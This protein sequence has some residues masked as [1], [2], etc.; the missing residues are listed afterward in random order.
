LVRTDPRERLVRLLN[1]VEQVIRLDEKVVLQLSDYRLPDGTSFAF[2]GAE[3]RDLPGVRLGARDDEGPVWLEVARLARQ[4]PP[5]P[6]AEIA[7]W[8]VPS[9]DPA[10]PPRSRSRRLI[11][12]DAA[13]RDLAVANGEVRPE[14]VAETSRKA[15]GPT[16][17]PPSFELTLRLDQRP[18]VA[19]KIAEWIA[20]PWSKWA[21]D[22]Q[23]RRGTI[24]IYQQLYKL[25][26]MI[27]VG[28]YESPI[29]LIWG[30]GLV[31]WQKDGRVVDRPLLEIRADLE[32][33]DTSGGLIR[34]R[35]TGGE[36]TFD[37]KP[38]EELGCE[39][40][41]LGELPDLIRRE[42]KKS[43]EA[44]GLSPFAPDSFEPILAA[45]ASRLGDGG[46]Y[47]QSAN[48][49]NVEIDPKQLTVTDQWVLFARPRSQH[50]L[51]QDIGRLRSVLED[52]DRPI[53]GL[54]ERL[55]TEPSK[56]APVG[57]WTPPDRI[58]AT[59]GIASPTQDEAPF[60]VFFPKPYNDDQ[61]ELVRR[62]KQTD[63]FVVQGPPGT[64]K[65]HTIANLICHAMATGERVLVVS[66]G[67]AA[68]AVLKD[69][70]PKEVQPLA[71]AV[72]SNE[73]QGLR[74]LERAIREIE[75]V[76]EGT[77]PEKR[78]SAIRRL[79]AEIDGLRKRIAAI[80]QELDAIAAPHFS[81]IGPRGE[82]AV[83]LA[84]RVVAERDTF[85]WFT[86]R[87]AN[88]AAETALSEQDITT[89]ADARRRAGDFLD[90][91]HVDLPLPANLPSVE[92]VR[93]WHDDLV[94]ASQL[95]ENDAHQPEDTSDQ[96]V[97]R[98]RIPSDEVD[99]ASN[100]AEVLHNFAA[101]HPASLG[102]PWIEPLRRAAVKGDSPPSLTMLRE[103]LNEWASLDVDRPALARRSVEL[104]PGLLESA[105][106]REAVN[107][108]AA[109]ERPWSL[110]STGK[111]TA[112][113]LV[114]SIR[115]DGTSV[116]DGDVNAWR[117]VAAV[118]AHA[119]RRHEIAA[120]WDSFAA[121]VGAPPSA[122]L[123]NTVE[124][125]REVIGA[126]DDVFALRELLATIISGALS[127]DALSDS[128]D[129]CHALAKQI[130]A[131]AGVMRL[132]AARE[133]IQK[134][135]DRFLRGSD[136]TSTLIKQFLGQF[137]G[138]PEVPGERIE[139]TWRSA[140]Q[141][142]T[143]IKAR[144]PAYSTIAKVTDQ[145]AKAGAPAWAERARTEPTL[146]TDPVLR[147][148]WRDAWDHAAANVKLASID[149]REKLAT[150]VRERDESDARCRN[151]FTDLVRERIFF[152]LDR[153]LSPAVKSA[154][155][156]FVRALAKIGKG[157]GKTA[158]THRSTAREAMARCYDAIPCWIMPTWRVAE[159][160]P[161]EL[162]VFDLVIIDEA[163]QSDVTELPALLRGRKL[164]VVGDDRQVS[165]TAPFV[166]QE[167][168]AQLRR[169]YL[170]DLPF[171]NLLEPGE[172]IYDLMRAVFP[173]D[174]LM[175]KEHFRCVEPIIR[176]STQ[177]YPERLLPLRIPT[178]QER[179]EPPLVDIYVPAGK[180]D[181]H[182]KTN[183]AEAN[184][185]VEEIKALT[186]QAAHPRSIGV[187]SLIGSEQAEYIRAT[188]SDV[189][190]EELMQRHAI[191]CG[192]SATFQGT[193]RDVV[194]LSMV[195]DPA[196]RTALTTLR[197][198]QRFNVAVSRAR[199]R[200]VLVRSLRLEDL[201]PNDLKAR[202]I[203]HF[204]EPMRLDTDVMRQGLD[205]CE[206]GFERD[207][208]RRLLERGYRVQPQVGPFGF[209][210]DL[211]IEGADGRRLAIECDGDRF[212]GPEQW[213]DDMRRQRVLERAGWQFWR[214][215]ASSF[216]RDMDGVTA[217]LFDTLS[218]LGIEPVPGGEP[219]AAT[220]RLTEHRIA[221]A[222]RMAA[223]GETGVSPD[224][225]S[226]TADIAASADVN[227]V[228]VGDKIVLLFGDDQRRLSVQ[229]TNGPHDLGKGVVS[230]A[231]ALGIAVSGAEEG[232]EIEFE[233]EDGQRRRAVIEIVMPGGSDEK[234]PR[235]A[236]ASS[237]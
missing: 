149:A 102:A 177:F 85:A 193:E 9:S 44:N 123:K 169:H 11:T 217:D 229:L 184:V 71:I 143:A 171:K 13:G 111:G 76:V 82:T 146:D 52:G 178:A 81:K 234:A 61:I 162:G 43:G 154:L 50:V 106:A 122:N 186:Q 98:L 228:A 60:D 86:D 34:I 109:G 187:I 37:L 99:R 25:F 118:M 53:S 105:E 208:M 14:D 215:F 33:D 22:E 47:L 237:S 166:T 26:Q 40:E 27:E 126:A 45:A 165:P 226:P 38:F 2:T 137:V 77:S 128:P 206:T 222:D 156:E 218:R 73:R 6:P 63:G 219:A 151:L 131:A 145:I 55:V 88:F 183:R 141:R 144:A 10:S 214:C 139:S 127:V 195:A 101:T 78:G 5:S 153:R 216:Y 113:T 185:I 121:E 138:N 182:R 125:A 221:T 104:P 97:P 189:V 93:R 194:F 28:G 64:G 54:A 114:A 140:L 72:L 202:L 231:S 79:E 16:D 94:R 89:L 236:V 116:R 134:V 21:A 110:F 46:R 192:D 205:A 39:G 152:E 62:L 31:H 199:D 235:S 170:E 70:L 4:E 211:V 159:Q 67:E 17:A 8:V 29:E 41:G 191:L 188:L 87:P 56:I 164:L 91:L 80:D 161:A 35:P 179:L 230:T 59:T 207:V 117:H 172:S 168:I 1:Y 3:H 112:K 174:R 49:A 19:A 69:Q 36:P 107:R 180:R 220:A 223:D 181:R 175:L 203:A 100:L 83:E 209:R 129:L 57:A 210:I 136:R 133:Q 66:R 90:H 224:D 108:A 74:Q 7:D 42:L 68:L 142:L 48:E 196:I 150:L 160:L 65:T 51:L 176:F 30:I 132:R 173:S 92:V 130:G 157:T 103:R 212:H 120:R 148:D 20:G 190:G 227:G 232:E 158:G 200:V 155:V 198:E 32:L 204:K 119:A 75:G 225:A 197:Y 96:P 12:A 201:N 147:H 124:V 15:D 135:I 213:R 23:R 163:S 24:A 84:H 167:R 18:E 233:Q 95:H 58:G 115:L